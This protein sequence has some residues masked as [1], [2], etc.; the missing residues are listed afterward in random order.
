MVLK[1]IK[2]HLRTVGTVLD[3]CFECLCSDERLMA[4]IMLGMMAG[5]ATQWRRSWV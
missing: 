2:T 5:L 4:V 1:T 3:D